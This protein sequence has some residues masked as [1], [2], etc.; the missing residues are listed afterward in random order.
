MAT[1]AHVEPLEPATAAFPP[2]VVAQRE[3]IPAIYGSVDFT[4]LPERFSTDLSDQVEMPVR[5]ASRR[6]ELLAD[7][8]CLATIRGYTMMGDRTA[9]AYAALMPEYGFRALVDM[10]D[11]ACDR[12]IEAVEDAPQELRAFIAA[13]EAKPDWLD[14]DLVEQGARAE[15]NAHVHLTPFVLRGAFIATFMNKYSAL[16]MALTGTLSNNTASR[17]AYETGS[18]FTCTL[19]P[20]A[21][22][23][24]GAGFKAAAKVR[25]MHSMVRA[26]IMRSG[27]WDVGVYGI[28]IPQVDQMPAGL[29]GTYLMTREVLDSGRETFTPEER[30]KVELARYRCFLLGLPEDLL[31][32]TPRGIEKL[33]L[34]RSAT[35]RAEFEPETCGALLR[36]TMDAEMTQGEGALAGAK[37]WMEG[38]FSKLFFIQHFMGGD[39]ELAESV[40]V[41]MS[42]ADRLAAL[43]ALAF[44]HGQIRWYKVLAAVPVARDWADRRL[45][46][47]LAGLLETY[48]HA[49][50][51]TDASQYKPAL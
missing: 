32:D 17:R 11:L 42:G 39:R 25:L 4:Q 24:T 10:L 9:D 18:F 16:P 41:I 20:G 36:A 15:R 43:C 49:D 31:S 22:R 50:F 21:L 7:S 23:R 13:M 37:R 44:V 46:R 19:M 29:I 30:A 2:E 35:L 28:P 6:A 3:A 1:L 47:K 51:V 14:M 27:K 26:N 33:W 40:D 8:E 38:G 48:G 12:G 5:F 34:T 45:V